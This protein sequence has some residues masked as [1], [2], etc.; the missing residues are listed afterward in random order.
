MMES[1]DKAI[2]AEEKKTGAPLKA[3]PPNPA[4]APNAQS[5]QPGCTVLPVKKPKFH[6]PKSVQ[7]AINKCT[8][9][10]SSKTGV[11]LDPNAPAQ[12]VN[13]GQGKPCPASPA[14]KPA[15]R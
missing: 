5:P 7:D 4:P 8:K 2:A 11:D 14:P 13:D 3:A 9:Q 6:I 1:V 12:A 15:N 10:V